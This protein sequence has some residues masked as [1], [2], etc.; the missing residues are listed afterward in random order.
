MRLLASHCKTYDGD[1]W[2]DVKFGLGWFRH[3]KNHKWFGFTIAFYC[4]NNR[5]SLT[6]VGNHE[7]YY[8][9]INYRNRPRI[10]K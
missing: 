7:E 10:K 9:K 6:F 3:H 1:D 4:F 8:K 5:L 2:G